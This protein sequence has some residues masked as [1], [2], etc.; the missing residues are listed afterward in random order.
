MQEGDIEV[1]VGDEGLES[2]G[3]DVCDIIRSGKNDSIDRSIGR[4]SL[5]ESRSA[6]V[7]FGGAMLTEEEVP[8][9]ENGLSLDISDIS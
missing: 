6:V 8:N 1:E 5:D 3:E 7:V 9:V 4:V 2:F